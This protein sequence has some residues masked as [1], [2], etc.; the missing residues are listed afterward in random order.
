MNLFII[1][2]LTEKEIHSKKKKDLLRIIVV[3]YLQSIKCFSTHSF[4]SGK[5]KSHEEAI[6]LTS[7]GLMIGMLPVIHHRNR[8]TVHGNY[9]N[10]K[11]TANSSRLFF[12]VSGHLLCHSQKQTYSYQH[13]H[14]HTL[15]YE[16]ITIVSSL[17]S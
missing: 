15:Q 1:T 16:L 14:K 9:L 8:A 13:D 10:F 12:D 3:N 7:N 6:S 4:N 17:H 5:K 11:R 2:L